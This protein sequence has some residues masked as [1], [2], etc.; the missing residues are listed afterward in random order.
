MQALVTGGAQ[1]IGL[2]IA[3]AHIYNKNYDL[4]N[5]WILFTENYISTD[6]PL[7]PKIKSVKLL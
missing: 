5:K 2:E 1:G 6:S 4:A 7:V 3:K